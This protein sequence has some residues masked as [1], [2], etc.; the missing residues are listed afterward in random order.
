MTIDGVT[1]PPRQLLHALH[2]NERHNAVT[3]T[4]PLPVT[5]SSHNNELGIGIAARLRHWG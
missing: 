3:L 4:S 1:P 5:W 2:L